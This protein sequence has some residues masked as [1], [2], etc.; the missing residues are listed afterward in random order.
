MRHA[1]QARR[2]AARDCPDRVAFCRTPTRLHVR[3]R[4][5]AIGA[6]QRAGE[7]CYVVAMVLEGDEIHG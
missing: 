2:S 4:S 6:G 1:R 7:T 3:S 5:F